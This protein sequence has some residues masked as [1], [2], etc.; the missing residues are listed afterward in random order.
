MTQKTLVFYVVKIS[1]LPAVGRQQYSECAHTFA[2]LYSLL[3]THYQFS[4]L[5][6]METTI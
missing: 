6:E 1:R 4:H 5:N 2:T 3:N